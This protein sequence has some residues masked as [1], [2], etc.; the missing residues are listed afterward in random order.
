MV[1]SKSEERPG[2]QAVGHRQVL[3]VGAWL[4]LLNMANSNLPAVGRISKY[5]YRF[6]VGVAGM[7][8]TSSIVTACFNGRSGKLHYRISQ[9]FVV[10]IAFQILG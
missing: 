10:S 3:A 5:L 9:L 7:S 1:G 4:S 8:C 6:L 2:N